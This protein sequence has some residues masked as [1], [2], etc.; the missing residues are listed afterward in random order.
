MVVVG[1]GGGGGGGDSIKNFRGGGKGGIG[2]GGRV[3]ERGKGGGPEVPPLQA[4]KIWRSRRRYF[5]GTDRRRRAR[6]RGVPF[7]PWDGRRGRA[8]LFRRGKVRRRPG[9]CALWC[10]RR[11]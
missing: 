4:R 7:R 5:R 6:F 9:R 8:A 1:G 2:G 11:R 10:C 3:D